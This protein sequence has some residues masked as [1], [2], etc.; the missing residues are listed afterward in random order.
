[1]AKVTEDERGCWRPN[2]VLTNSGYATTNGGKFDHR[3]VY[4]MFI[5]PI[6]RDFHGKKLPLDHSCRNRWCWNPRHL[7]PVTR[8]QNNLLAAI[9][10][11]GKRQMAY[12]QLRRARFLHDMVGRDLP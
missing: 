2:L 6:P 1:M 3:S 9:T 5:G 10:A 4:E 12:G 11:G 7:R 8:S